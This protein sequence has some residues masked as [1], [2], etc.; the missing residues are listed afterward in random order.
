[1]FV[2][3]DGDKLLDC[4]ETRARGQCPWERESAGRGIPVTGMFGTPCWYRGKAGTWMLDELAGAG[5]PLPPELGSGFYGI[6]SE[7]L[8]PEY[9]IELA[10]FME[11][12]VEAFAALHQ[13]DEDGGKEAIETY[14]YAAW[15]LRFVAEY[16][17]G[18]RSWW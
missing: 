9:C 8:P 15:W 2:E 3:R 18:A 10:W 17:D 14:R 16:A 12:H 11:A 7:E 1:V 13:A 4:D 6:G 5:Y